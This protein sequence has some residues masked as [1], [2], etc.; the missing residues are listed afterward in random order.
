MKKTLSIFIVIFSLLA[1]PALA[2][3]EKYTCPM[4][5]HY[6]ADRPG[7]C[8]I[9]GMDLVELEIDGE[10]E[11]GE[12]SKDKQTQQ[13]RT[14]VTIDPE[15]IQNSGIRKKTA[16]MASFGTLVRSYGDVTEN[17]RLQNDISARVEGWIVDLSVQA[18]GD[19][20]KKGDLL[21]KLYSPALISAQRDLISAISTE[22][23]G[24]IDSA[25]KRLISLGMQKQA[26][27]D[28][29]KSR[30]ALENVPF[31][32]Q[33]DGLVSGISVRDGTYAKP[34]MNL[35]TLQG[36]DTVWIDVNVAEQDIPFINKE[37][38]ATVSLPA[39]G[40]KDQ[41]AAIDYIYPVIDQATRTGRVRLVLDNPEGKL[42]PG[43]YADVE[44]ETDVEKRLAIPS[45]AV[46]K[47]KDGDYVV[48]SQGQGRFQPQKIL[49][50]LTYKGYSEVL[51]GLSEDDE[52]V[53][54]GQFLI[55]SE[56]ALR[57][58]FRKMQTMQMPL[59]LLDVSEEQLAMIDHLIDAAIYIQKEL[60]DGRTPNPNMIMP[61]ISLGDHLMPIFRGTKLQFVLEDAEI[62]L[63]ASKDNVTDQEWQNSLN[64][65]VIALKPWL[66]EGKP[67]HY[68]SK[69][70]KL[71]MAH[72]LDTYW[73]QLSDEVQNPYGEGHPMKIDWPEKV[74]A[75]APE[76]TEMPAGG[77]HANH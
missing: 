24:R 38:Q 51:E 64:T 73:L 26:I 36:Y 32:A 47:S 68:K 46:L 7:T 44:F 57:E 5:P 60:N 18:M 65:L 31:Y 3:A 21:F 56:S 40:I 42:K 41:K 22:Y 66:L 58:S 52:I 19:E 8:P 15:T 54:S 10:A 33:N 77:A 37:T 62:A 71:Y 76:M 48:L 74:D 9:C 6:V 45:D 69:N 53:V 27:Q 50:G 35:I 17:I 25:S 11:A 49:T 13:T 16:Q 72:G 75:Q 28:V 39:L 2:Q 20:V 70:L 14:S 67:Q 1:V 61:A 23:K 12:A 30:K 34:G 59:A 43:A 63:K 4:H 29:K 55:D